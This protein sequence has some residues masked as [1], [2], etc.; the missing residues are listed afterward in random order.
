MYTQNYTCNVTR[1]NACSIDTCTHK[2]C[3]LI[4]II[5]DN[6]EKNRR[7]YNLLRDHMTI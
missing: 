6:D 3:R 1:I 2:K 7:F 4:I 5:I